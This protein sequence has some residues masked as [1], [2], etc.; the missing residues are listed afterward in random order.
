M[1]EKNPASRSYRRNLPH[2]QEEGKALFVTFCTKD[3]RILDPEA[4]SVVLDCCRYVHDRTAV[5]HGVV[6]MPDHVHLIL[7]PLSDENGQAW[8]L[9]TILRGI[10]GVSTR[11]V[12]LL[13]RRE[14]PLWL[15]ES[16][17]HMLR[18]EESAETKVEY[19]AYNPVRKGLVKTPE[20][21]PWLW[22]LSGQQ[23]SAS[24]NGQT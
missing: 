10:K 3:A 5:L 15:G 6:V 23:G 24:V 21:Y 4:R 2:I 14:G 20:E 9:E 17:D 19:I 18:G 22:R 8:R 16:F 12:N 13:L 11:R 1:P 7:T